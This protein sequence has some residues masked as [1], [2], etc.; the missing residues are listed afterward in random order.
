MRKVTTALAA[1]LLLAGAT[2]TTSAMARPGGS[3]GG[4]ASVGGAHSSFSGGRS[5]FNGN[6]GNRAMVGSNV[7]PGVRPGVQT[8]NRGRNGFASRGRR[9]WNG[10]YGGLYAY[11]PACNYGWPYQDPYT[12]CYS[13]Y[14]NGYG[15]DSG[16]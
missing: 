15:P 1:T 3:T 8:Y 11:Q 9:G 16:W 14:G 6:V 10:G 7:R 5:T 13:D 4:H 2:L 12:N